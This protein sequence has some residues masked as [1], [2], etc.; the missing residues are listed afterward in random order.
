M[1]H[2]QFFYFTGFIINVILQ[3]L[4]NQCWL[5]IECTLRNKLEWNQDQNTN[6][7]VQINEFDL[8]NGGQFIQASMCS[9]MFQLFWKMSMETADARYVDQYAYFY[10]TYKGDVEF[11]VTYIVCIV[12]SYVYVE[13]ASQKESY[14]DTSLSDK[15]TKNMK[16]WIM[17]NTSTSNTVHKVN[18]GGTVLQLRVIWWQLHT[19]TFGDFNPHYL[20]PQISVGKTTPT[21][22]Y[23]HH[24]YFY[25]YC[26]YSLGNMS[27]KCC[28]M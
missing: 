11:A 17:K 21:W 7:V 24:N 2:R 8:Q 27:C 10:M 6:I 9:D 15:L 20:I 23:L 1:V 26:V 13:N 22:A 16:T 25:S 5:V 12:V 19:Q 18:D 28:D 4:L 3:V 14:P